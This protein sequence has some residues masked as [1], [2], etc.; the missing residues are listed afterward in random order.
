MDRE[1]RKKEKNLHFA[2]M[3]ACPLAL[4]LDSKSYNKL[5]MI[6]Q[7]NHRKE[8]QT[9]KQKLAES[10][11]MISITSQQCTIESL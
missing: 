9:I 7:L 4:S 5:Q 11:A 1:R 2:F 10:K 6:A 3:F 8:F